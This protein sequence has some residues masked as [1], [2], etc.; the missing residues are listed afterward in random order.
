MV[1]L[2]FFGLFQMAYVTWA[3]QHIVPIAEMH[4]NARSGYTVKIDS[5]AV[6]LSS[7]VFFRVRVLDEGK[8]IG[9]VDALALHEPSL[10]SLLFTK[11]LTARRVEVGAIRTTRD[12]I[13]KFFEA[14]ATFSSN[15]P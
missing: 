13:R 15:P 7:L 12:D 1:F 14:Q 3:E 10:L 8:T 9:E 6:S 2:L 4:L 11:E 5:V